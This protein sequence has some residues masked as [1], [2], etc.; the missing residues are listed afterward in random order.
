MGNNTPM[1]GVE[2]FNGMKSITNSTRDKIFIVPRYACVK[3]D[4]VM[5]VGKYI[6]FHDTNNYLEDY[7]VRLSVEGTEL[8]TNAT[9]FVVKNSKL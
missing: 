2:T 8:T 4:S 9:E 6:D 7:S 5:E 3:S 1:D